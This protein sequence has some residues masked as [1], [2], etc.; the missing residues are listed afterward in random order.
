[1][2]AWIKA[3]ANTAATGFIPGAVQGIGCQAASWVQTPG[4]SSAQLLC[5]VEGMKDP[6]LPGTRGLPQAFRV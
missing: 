6:C 3:A 1:M 4:P 5:S 2:G